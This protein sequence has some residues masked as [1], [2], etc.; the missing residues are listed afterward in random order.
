M[1]YFDNAASI[2]V[3]PDIKICYAELLEKFSGNI[4]AAHSLGHE[5][6][7]QLKTLENQLFDLLLPGADPLQRKVFFADSATTLINAVGL[8]A[9][10]K[11]SAVMASMLDHPA[12]EKM[13]RRSFASVKN[14]PLDRYGRIVPQAGEKEQ[15]ALIY[16]TLLQ[17]EIGVLQDIPQLMQ[18]FRKKHPQTPVLADAVQFTGLYEYPVKEAFLPDMLLV[19]GAKLGANS[20]AAL[21]CVGNVGCSIA[22]SLETLRKKEHLLPRVNIVEAAALVKAVEI[23]H[24]QRS[25]DRQSIDRI[26]GFLRAELR[27]MVLPN[28]KKLILTVPEEYA[29]KNILHMILPGYQS[30]VLVRMFGQRGIMLSAGSACAAESAEPSAVLS[31]LNY[32]KSDS[33]SGLRLSFSG[34]NTIEE[35]AVFVQTLRELLQNY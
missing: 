28:G 6:K 8:A 34:S 26:N 9:G 17:S 24:L 4:E 13:F 3:L 30:G 33:Y 20:G 31:A 25:N 35:A 32:S 2:P 27:D 29:A 7:N 19:S 16:L 14:L 10:N 23:A 15:Y 12:A 11:N 1:I 22:S 5:L 18:F 21:L